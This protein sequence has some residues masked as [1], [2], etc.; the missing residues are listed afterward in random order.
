M[1]TTNAY[2]FNGKKLISYS[3]FDV[4]R[5]TLLNAGI[6]ITSNSVKDIFE[7][8]M[9]ER[10]ERK[11]EVDK[12]FFEHVFYGQLKNIYFH[13]IN[14]GLPQKR[15]FIQK[16]TRIINIMNRKESIPAQYHDLFNPAGFY[17]L[18]L[19]NIENKG[20]VFLLGFDYTENN[21]RIE[22]ARFLIAQVVIKNGD[23]VYYLSALEINYTDKF[24]LLMFR[25][26][27]G[28]DAVPQ[29]GLLEE[30]KWNKSMNGYISKINSLILNP[31]DISV[32]FRFRKD[33]AGMYSMCKHLDDEL[34]AEYR[35]HIADNIGTSVE[36][37]I[38]SWFETLFAEGDEPSGLQKES[39]K[40]KICSQA[41]SLYLKNKPEIDLVE[42]AKELGQVGYTTKIEFKA[43]QAGRGATKSKSGSEPIATEDMFHSLYIDF[44][45]ALELPKWSLAWFTDEEDDYVQTTIYITKAYFKIIF[46]PTRHL[47]KESIYHVVR[48]V[49]GFRNYEIP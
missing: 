6:D 15:G 40:N 34:L 37:S 38:N 30:E 39:L 31:L 33:R 25:N 4:Y 21:N 45:D 35:V 47:N 49:G 19:L 32:N 29:T 20:N 24:Y 10:P 44:K 26:L 46:L 14:N 41:L 22:L 2:L 1:T 7:E 17:A 8:I 48:Y 43:N 42:K 5:N 16:V 23:P 3:H 27:L 36:N 11:R 28:I 18:D 9:E 12:L 13:K